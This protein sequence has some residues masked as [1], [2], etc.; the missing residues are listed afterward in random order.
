M[1]AVVESGDLADV[2]DNRGRFLG[3]GYLNPRST[4]VV[5]LLARDR[6]PIDQAFF[7]NRIREAQAWRNKMVGERSAYRV[8]HGE[9]DGLPGLVVDRY[10]DS[11]AIQLLTAGM[12]RRRSLILRALE[13]TLHP[14][15]IVARNDSP[16][17]EREGLPRERSVIQGDP[18]P[19]PV[20]QV[21][22]LAVEVD[23]L[24][25]QKTGL[26][27][28]QT[29]NYRLVERLAPE[30]RVLDCFCY[31]GLWA[32]H[33][34]RFG[35]AHVIGVDQSATAVQQATALAERNGLT[36][37]CSFEA[38]NVFDDLNARDRRRE[39]FDM[40]ILD[41]PAFV[42]TRSRLAEALR[43]YK[44]INLRAM[45]LLK[46]G[47]FLITCSCS[48]HLQAERF[49][50]L[51]LEVAHDVQRSLKLVAQGRQGTDHPILL[52]MAETE[53]LKCL[54]LQIL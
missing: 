12:E 47:G 39:T 44:E 7:T 25:G 6:I 54:V 21:N 24:G 14:Q 18:N 52:G 5:R 11:L 13:D 48:H 32:L 49:R 36:D 2:H 16:M 3:R 4:I 20:V 28:D 26:F 8:V 10:A 23:L 9:A 50:D 15:T 51:L 46:P 33:A 45:R 35:A 27:L 29:D 43:G 34:A 19:R 37:R 17:R 22:G 40:I 1:P 42:K 41:P 30:A 53:Y 38:G 31:A